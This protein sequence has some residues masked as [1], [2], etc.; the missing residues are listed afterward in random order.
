M[1]ADEGELGELG[2]AVDEMADALQQRDRALQTINAELEER[3]GFRTAELARANTQLM[4]SQD[5]LRRLSRD[6]LEVAEEERIRLA[7]DVSDDIGQGLTGIKMDVVL[8]QRHLAEGKTTEAVGHLAAAVRN[9]DDLIRS[10]RHIAGY[11]RPSVLDDFGLTAAVEGQL[12]EFER[13]TN[14]QTELR[15]D[16]DD[17]RL[18][19]SVSTAAFRVLQEALRNVTQHANA[20]EVFVNLTTA[21]GRL[22]LEVRDDGRGFAPADLTKPQSMGVLGMRERALQLG[23][24]LEIVGAPGEG[25]KLTL[26]LPLVTPGN[27]GTVTD[28]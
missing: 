10:A 2:H 26:I 13:Q 4:A 3:V 11:L 12:A 23:G 14:A 24:S 17:A 16:V 28:D 21:D 19:K 18:N 5:Q 9:L 25:A 20:S 7:N 22:V 15:A 6:L 1:T 8:A 27:V